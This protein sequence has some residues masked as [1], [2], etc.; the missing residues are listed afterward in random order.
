[1]TEHPPALYGGALAVSRAVVGAGGE[2]VLTFEAVEPG[3]ALAVPREFLGRIVHD[4]CADSVVVAVGRTSDFLAHFSVPVQLAVAD[5]AV[6][7]SVVEQPYAHVLSPSLT[8]GSSISVSLVSPKLSSGARLAV[9]FL[10]LEWCALAPARL[11]DASVCVA[12]AVAV[13]ASDCEQSSPWKGAS[14]A[15]DPLSRQIPWPEH[16]LGHCE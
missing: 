3:I 4:V 7:D 5:S 1:M 15:H 11:C 13:A 6:A 2:L 16:W 12:V 8:E 9:V 14:H 10:F